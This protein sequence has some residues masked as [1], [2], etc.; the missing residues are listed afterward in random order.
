MEED[1]KLKICQG[2]DAFY[3]YFDGPIQVVANYAKELDQIS[4]CKVIT[5]RDRNKNY[6]DNQPYEV[7]RVKSIPAP[8][9]YRLV[10]PMFDRKLKKFLKTEKFDIVHLHSPFGVAK[11]LIK[12]CRRH[13]IPSVITLHTK[14]D[15]DI[16]RV[17]KI[18]FL[19]KLALKLIMKAFH[20]AD[21]VW[22]VNSA[23]VE[24]LHSYGYKGEVD[25]VKNGT[26]MKYPEKAEELR[27]KVIE[28]HNLSDAGIVFIFVG[29]IVMYKNLALICE[30]LKIAKEKGL[31][32]KMLVVGFGSDEEAFKNKVSECGLDSDFIFAGKILDREE[33]SGYYLASDLFLFP[34]VFDTASLVPIEA[35]AHKIPTL[36]IRGCSTAEGTTDNV[37]SYHADENADAYAQRILEITAD[38][39]LLRETGENAYSEIYRS[40]GKAAE[41]VYT[42]YAEIIEKH[43]NKTK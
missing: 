15:Q 13:K 20:K 36:L 35:A 40:W 25:I 37:N 41:E 1:K 33:L 31:K 32:F 21:Y 24:T 22:T 6:K 8:L 9:G 23:T 2:I 18:K 5:A 38:R 10:V 7:F 4:E 30:A 14:F 26:D 28:K 39:E 27:N 11:H 12:F 29:R 3:P 19:Q 34:S 42:K 17:T 16:A 43:K